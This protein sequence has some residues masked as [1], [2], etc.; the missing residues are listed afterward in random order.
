M[1]IYKFGSAVVYKNLQPV[2]R[3]NTTMI[4][5][6]VTV[7]FFL[8]LFVFAGANLYF[9]NTFSP[10]LYSLTYNRQ[11]EAAVTFLKII[12]FSPDFAAQRAYFQE[13]Y[14][15]QALS[16]ITTDAISRGNKIQQLESSLSRNTKS[17]DI[18][19]R[20]ALLYL[21]DGQE[22]K[23]HEYYKRVRSIDPWIKIDK[24]EKTP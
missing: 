24:L 18:L 14:G 2:F 23:A 21:D 19:I 4:T 11:K 9:A 12:Q 17:R 5:K 1:L 13:I 22:Q 8:V 6:G 7:I 15:T 16:E 20:L 3:Y 10:L